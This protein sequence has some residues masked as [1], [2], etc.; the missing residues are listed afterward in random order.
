VLLY[1]QVHALPRYF[2]TRVTSLS[3]NF[4][5]GC[6]FRAR[7]DVNDLMKRREQMLKENLFAAGVG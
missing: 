4:L 1:W 5:G 7:W 6:Y 2:C 3:A